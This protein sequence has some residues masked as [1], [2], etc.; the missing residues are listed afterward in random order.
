M[1]VVS[2][3]VLL[4]SLLILC[5]LTNASSLEIEAYRLI[6]Y[7]IRDRSGFNANETMVD[8]MINFGSQLATINRE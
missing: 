5:S 8:K 7:Q 1:A 2:T 3:R 4:A 6:Q